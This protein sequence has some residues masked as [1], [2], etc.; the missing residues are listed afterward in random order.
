M[1]CMRWPSGAGLARVIVDIGHRATRHA[2]S[3]EGSRGIQGTLHVFV[4][5]MGAA[6]LTAIPA[7]PLLGSASSIHRKATTCLA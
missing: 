7:L 4:V 1:F 2:E 6:A 3:S 5:A